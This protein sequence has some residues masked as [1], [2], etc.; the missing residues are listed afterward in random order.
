MSE[1]DKAQ[2]KELK[3]GAI[4]HISRLPHLKARDFLIEIAATEKDPDVIDRID[5]HLTE[6]E[7]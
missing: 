4:D 2:D 1:M 3:L 6:L 5:V 7:Q